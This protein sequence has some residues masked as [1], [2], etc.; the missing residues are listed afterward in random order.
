MRKSILLAAAVA[1]GL[2]AA[3]PGDWI[4]AAGGS[5]TRDAG[6][7]IIA[8]NLRA[9]WVT[10]SDLPDLAR[11][12]DLAKLDLSL[13]RVSDRGLQQLKTASNLTELN[14]YYAELITDQGLAVVKSL[15]R[16][17]R[18]DVRGTKATDSTLAF[19]S[20]VPSLESLDI[21][22]GQVTDVGLAQLTAPNLKELAIGGNKL[23][24]NGLQALRR[25]TAL[26]D[27]DLSGAQ[28]TDS[29]L[30]SISLTE[31]GLDTISMLRELRH[32]RLNG[33][34][35]TDLGIEKLK[36]LSHLER[37]DL[38]LC[39]RITDGAVAAIVALPSLRLVDVTG[40]KMTGNGIAALRRAEPKLTV[41]DA[42]FDYTRPARRGPAN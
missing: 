3:D 2:L 21:G 22:Y 40:T 19:L 12:P 33:T 37:L 30:W 23:T 26:I 24:D 1:S 5:V 11:L 38:Q 10:D 15:T 16:L 20:S 17:K 27:L 13:T 28:R 41:L 29:G 9:S 8:V 34:A 7:R 31:P 42:D 6:G 32:L 39:G 4:S 35:V 36:S 18:L 25:M 14:L